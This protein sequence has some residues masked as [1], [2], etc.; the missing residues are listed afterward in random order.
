MRVPFANWRIA[1]CSV[2]NESLDTFFGEAFH[3]Y[4]VLPHPPVERSHKAEFVG[5]HSLKYPRLASE[6]VKSG[7]YECS[8]PA[9]FF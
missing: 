1:L 3:F 7:M 5:I 9:R 2:A 4:L 8:G 6:S